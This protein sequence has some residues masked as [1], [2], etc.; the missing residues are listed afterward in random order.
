MILAWSDRARRQPLRGPP[1][2]PARARGDRRSPPPS[3][4]VE[5]RQYR[6]RRV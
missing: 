2:G 6:P 5:L 4:F 1:L 3:R